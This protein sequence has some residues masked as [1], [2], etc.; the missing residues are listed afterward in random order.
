[1]FSRFLICIQ[2]PTAS[3]K[4]N[5]AI[6]LAQ[7]YHC[8]II[9][10]DSRQFY[11]EMNIGTAKPTKEQLKSI[12]HHF[13]S[14]IS[15]KDNFNAFDFEVAALELLNH[16][17]RNNKV[18]ILTG[19]SGLYFDAV[20]K[21]FHAIPNIDKEIREQLKKELN[22]NGLN[23]LQSRLQL[24]DTEIYNRIDIHNPS[25]VIRALE[26]CIG[27]NKP[28]STYLKPEKKTREFIP[29]RIG[30]LY[31][32]DVLYKRINKRCDEMI[33]NNLYEEVLGLYPMKGS[34]VLK[35]IGYKEFFEHVEGK[36]SWEEAIEKFKQHS[37]NYARKQLSWL[38]RDNNIH[39]FEPENKDD[40]IKYIDNFIANN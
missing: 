39:W 10:A 20:I 28:Y 7:H 36:L 8:E 4:T 29:V 16:L 9:S 6:Q 38:R 34:H 12:K 13:I 32:L 3:G 17:F 30:L 40:I 27:T 11:K 19:G 37:R 18:Q 21:G 15:I 35:T 5:L 2:G 22:T 31:P 26:I 24:L 1:M 25:R 23:D 33:G 14:F